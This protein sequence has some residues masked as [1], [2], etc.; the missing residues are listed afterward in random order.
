MDNNISN[1]NKKMVEMIRRKIAR[2]TKSTTFEK[3]ITL[4]QG[5]ISKLKVFNEHL[6][7]SLIHI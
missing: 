7:L 2:S 1:T 6:N 5:S 3:H 4:I